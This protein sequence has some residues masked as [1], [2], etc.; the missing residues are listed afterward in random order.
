MWP[1][2][3]AFTV[4]GIVGA[5]LLIWGNWIYF[6]AVIAEGLLEQ[7]WVKTMETGI[8][9][10]PWSSMDAE[11]AARLTVPALGVDQIVLS[12][13][14]GQALAFAPAI[15]EGSRTPDEPGLTAIAAHKNTHFAFL[16]HMSAGETLSLQTIDD[17]KYDYVVET[18]FV[19]DVRTDTLPQNENA[20]GLLLITC[21]PFDALSFNGPLRYV[22]SARKVKTSPAQTLIPGL[23]PVRSNDLRL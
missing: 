21:Y 8:P 4:V 15:V 10:T 7:A 19:M 20:D 1:K 11:L 13:A 3:S 5:A 17:V 14:T 23:G 6:K 9:A 12:D 22:V 2:K 16:E 18:G